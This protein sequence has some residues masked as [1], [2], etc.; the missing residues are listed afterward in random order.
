MEQVLAQ[1][2]CV[3]LP[4]YRE[5]LPRSLLEAGAMGLPVVATAVPG[6]RHVVQHGVNGL[7]CQVRDR[8]HWSRRWLPCWPW[9]PRIAPRWGQRA[10][11]SGGDVG[12]GAQSWS[13][14]MYHC[15][16]GFGML[17]VRQGRDLASG[18]RRAMMTTLAFD[19]LLCTLDS[20]NPRSVIQQW[21]Q[22][23]Q[24]CPSTKDAASW[25]E[26]QRL[27]CRFLGP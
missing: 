3:V 22:I 15:D 18:R 2:D 24:N 11:G 12:G 5:G 1:V 21:M 17:W 6:C 23:S 8:C 20:A 19:S 7:L 14:L 25:Y 27:R 9:P 4:S 13:V 26:S 10:P 16:G